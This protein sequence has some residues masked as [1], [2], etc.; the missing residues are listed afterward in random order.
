M[1][2]ARHSPEMP[3]LHALHAP[4]SEIPPLSTTPH[5]HIVSKRVRRS[6]VSP[7]HRRG[8]VGGQYA[9]RRAELALSSRHPAV[10]LSPT[11][12][13]RIGPKAA[14]CASSRAQAGTFAVASLLLRRAMERLLEVGRLLLCSLLRALDDLISAHIAPRFSSM[15]VALNVS[16]LYSHWRFAGA[17]FHS[18]H[19][20]VRCC[21][22]NSMYRSM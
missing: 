1:V 10:Q 13:P 6:P 18:A 2:T 5:R 9:T 3:G 20:G 7:A 8:W 22:S 16:S 14:A 17:A 11:H 15:D 12:T 19:D 4:W 21:E